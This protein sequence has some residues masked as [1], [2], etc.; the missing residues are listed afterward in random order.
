MNDEFWDIHRVRAHTGA[1]NSTI[2][3]MTNDECMYLGS[4]NRAIVCQWQL[5]NGVCS[6]WTCCRCDVVVIINHYQSTEMG[7]KWLL[8]FTKKL[9][10]IAA[11]SMHTFFWKQLEPKS[12]SAKISN[13]KKQTHRHR[14]SIKLSKLIRLILAYIIYSYTTGGKCKHWIFYCFHPDVMIKYS[15]SNNSTNMRPR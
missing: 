10:L 2:A 6:S 14:Q 13:K 4:R 7:N 8:S 15:N 9:E 5:G 1:E 3:N 11:G 12:E